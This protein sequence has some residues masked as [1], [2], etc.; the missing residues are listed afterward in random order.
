MRA[1]FDRRIERQRKR[2][3]RTRRT[4]D[5]MS[6]ERGDEEEEKKKKKK[7]KIDGPG[8]DRARDP[9]QGN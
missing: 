6:D 5:A 3:I 4:N 9:L 7:K 1:L 2:E 8:R